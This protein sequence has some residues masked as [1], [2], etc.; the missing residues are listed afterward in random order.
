MCSTRFRPSFNFTARSSLPVG[1]GLGSSAAYSAC[2]ATALLLLNRRVDL[3]PYPEPSRSASDNDPGH[4]H[5]SHQGR[6][7]LPPSVAEEINR[8][9]FVSEKVLHGNPSG[10]DNSVAVFG[11][12]LAYTKPGFGKKSGMDKIKGYVTT[13]LVTMTHYL[14]EVCRFKSLKFLLTD[15]KVS[16]DTKRLVAGVA[17]KKAEVCALVV[18]FILL[19]NSCIRS[20]KLLPPSSN[21]FR[22]SPMK[23]AALLTT[24]RCP[25]TFFSRRCL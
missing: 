8:W 4:T 20:L 6:R 24:Q 7:A 13:V 19:L 18:T 1:A 23:P 14:T 9:A 3:P 12:A 21:P 16:R 5:I 2:I 11:G 17:Q 10:V 22:A 15:S 25:V